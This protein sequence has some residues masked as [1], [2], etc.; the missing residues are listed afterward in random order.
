MAEA[1]P[2]PG[3]GLM[4]PPNGGSGFC[5]VSPSD[6][7]WNTGNALNRLAELEQRVA[8]LEAKVTEASQLSN[9]S[10]QVGWVGGVTYM[11]IPGW[12]M[13]E[14]GTLI[15]PPGMSLSSLGIKLSDGNTYN[16]VWM[17]EN[18]VLQ[19]GF[20]TTGQFVGASTST[21]GNKMMAT[22]YADTSN[23]GNEFSGPG[24]ITN[25]E[26]TVY[27]DPNGIID[28]ISVS[29]FR[30]TKTGY[31]LLA[32]TYQ[33]NVKSTSATGSVLCTWS[34]ANTPDFGQPY[35]LNGP[36]IAITP[37]STGGVYLGNFVYTSSRVAWL[38]ADVTNN[39]S[40]VSVTSGVTILSSVMAMTLSL[41]RETDDPST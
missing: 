1:L 26:I 21:F 25:S 10:G 39:A 41:M 13:T 24:G 40:Q 9:I 31:Y 27:S 20:T 4:V 28:P 12:T 34:I 18:G 38:K 36:E 22:V 8:E 37:G 30:V 16:A 29:Q 17:D 33:V 11:G 23:D 19:Y 6:L 7:A 35:R 5:S 32:L 3:G 2:E 15:P 14:Y